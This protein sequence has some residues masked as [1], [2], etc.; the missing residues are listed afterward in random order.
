MKRR[1]ESGYWVL[2]MRGKFRFFVRREKFRRFAAFGRGE[3]NGGSDF[4][5]CR[6]DRRRRRGLIGSG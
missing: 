5:G 2:G 4:R 1:V 6:S 3:R